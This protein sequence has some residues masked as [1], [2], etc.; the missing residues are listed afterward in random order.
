VF[1]LLFVVYLLPVGTEKSSGRKR[2]KSMVATATPELMRIQ[3]ESEER[4]NRKNRKATC[5]KNLFHKQTSAKTAKTSEQNDT[6]AMQSSQQISN[7][8]QRKRECKR[9]TAEKVK[10]LRGIRTGVENSSN[11]SKEQL[12]A[13]KRPHQTKSRTPAKDISKIQQRKPI[14]LLQRQTG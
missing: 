9:R 1:F 10:Q 12:V 4:L 5:K 11:I 13:K 14:W 2:G 7:T 3:Q 6:E 8:D